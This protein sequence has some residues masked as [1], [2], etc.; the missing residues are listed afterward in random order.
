LEFRGGGWMG[1]IV[2]NVYGWMDVYL[3]TRHFLF[4]LLRG[5][6]VSFGRGLLLIVSFKAKAK[7]AKVTIPANY[8]RLALRITTHEDVPF[9][10][11]RCPLER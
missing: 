2:E 8:S 4:P 1:I 10:M 9:S 11:S 5:S 6:L 3:R 7:T